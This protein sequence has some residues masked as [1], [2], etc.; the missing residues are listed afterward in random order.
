MSYIDDIIQVTRLELP[1]E[2]LSG[3]N[4]LITGATGL[5]G[6]CLVEVLMSRPNRDYRLFAMGR[7]VERMKKLFSQYEGDSNFK[8]IY[9]D[10]VL[11]LPI[12]ESF[13]YIVHAASGAAPND[14]TTRPVE[15]M[16]ANI[17][18]VIN[19]I[20]YGLKHNM[21]RFLYISSGEVYGEGDG[22]FF[23]E[24]Y[25][26]YVDSINPRSCYP[27]S[28]RAAETLCVSYADEY[29]ADVVIAR[30]CH[31]YG[32]HF[33][34]SDNRVFAQ[35]IRNVLRNEDI[36][37]KSKGEQ[38]R[39]WC[40][41]VDSVSAILHILL[42][43]KSCDAYNIAD[44]NSNISIKDLAEMIAKI[45]GCK[46]IVKIPE[47][48]ESKGFNVV[49]KSV[50]ITDKLETLGWD[51]HGMMCEKLVNTIEMAKIINK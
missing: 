16:K 5:I 46:V 41:V 9:G 36:V 44:K 47:E 29:G 42:N 19:L 34:E 35:F 23:T 12:E 11:Q 17:N 18:G 26:G 21:R 1:W 45:G 39:S 20:E 8:P 49:R 2:K 25:S 48:V 4:I 40:Y 15:V 10:V 27:S 13:H 33:T 31:I 51:I 7:N 32:P 24:E 22:R 43:G 38:F 37:M 28:K 14:F 6:S 50:F 30:P 3:T